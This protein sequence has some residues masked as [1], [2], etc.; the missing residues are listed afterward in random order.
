MKIC[1]LGDSI[2][3]GAGAGTVDNMYT[4]ILCKKLGAVE[5]NYGVCGTRIAKQATPSENPSD[6]EDFLVRA[7]KMDRDAD[8]VFVFGGTNDYG[9]GDA[10]IGDGTSKTPYTFCGAL[11]ILT[12][13]LVSQYGSQRLCFVLPLPRF[14]E[15]DPYGEKGCK[16][17]KGVPLSEYREAIRRIVGGYG[18]DVLDLCADF[19]EPVTDGGDALTIDGLHPN[20]KGHR[21]IAE[22][23]YHYLTGKLDLSEN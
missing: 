4:T 21:I 16:K 22:E 6:D 13:Y 2:T 11:R 23:L 12:E 19:P 5:K 15:N 10:P 9:H 18:V 14:H 8:F 20:P 7:M 1:F 3:I 17:A